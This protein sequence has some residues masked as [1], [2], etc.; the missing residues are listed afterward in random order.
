MNKEDFPLLKQNMNGYPIAYLD[1]G[2]TTQ[3]PESVIKA[4]TDYYKSQNANPHRGAYELSMTATEIYENTRIKTS[5]RI[6]QK[7]HRKND[8]YSRRAINRIAL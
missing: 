2:A 3:K 8:L 4:I 5:Y 6:S 1:N 7:K